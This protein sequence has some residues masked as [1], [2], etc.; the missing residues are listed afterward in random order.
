MFLVPTIYY[1]TG[2]KKFTGR[3]TKSSPVSLEKIRETLNLYKEVERI[4]E[5]PFDF[6]Y[7]GPE[8]E[9]RIP[10]EEEIEKAA[11]TMRNWKSP[12]LSRITV[13]DMKRW[14]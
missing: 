1:K 14:Y 10:T 12:G 5:L 9:D 7:D 2:K 6:D 11:F 3:T 13:K 4:N 8:V